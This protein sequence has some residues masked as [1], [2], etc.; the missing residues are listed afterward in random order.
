MLRTIEFH[1]I[2]DTDCQHSGKSDTHALSLQLSYFLA[3]RVLQPALSTWDA[4]AAV[5]GTVALTRCPPCSNPILGVARADAA[6]RSALGLILCAP[7]VL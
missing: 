3:L 5:V 2:V 1:Q 4:D 7:L 6:M